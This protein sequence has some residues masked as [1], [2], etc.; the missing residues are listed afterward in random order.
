MSFDNLRKDMDIYLNKIRERV[1]FCS[2][3]R[4]SY[5]HI[6]NHV[7]TIY[8]QAIEL[9]SLAKRGLVKPVVSNRFK[10]DQA[11][12]ALTMLTKGKIIGRGVINP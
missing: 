7:N 10:L 4:S 8:Y 9:V 1:T 2:K 5:A 3:F 12:E 11:T 6:W